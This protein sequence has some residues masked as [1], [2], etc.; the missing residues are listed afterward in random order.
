VNR[1]GSWFANL[2]EK[3]MRHT[4][5][6]ITYR[7]AHQAQYAARASELRKT[8]QTA[9]F[10]EHA[11]GA[12]RLMIDA[13]TTWVLT[14]F[15]RAEINPSDWVI[16][17]DSRC[18]EYLEDLWEWQPR[19]LLDSEAPLVELTRQLVRIASGESF[20]TTSRQT[21]RLTRTERRVLQSIAFGMEHKEI[22]A[23]MGVAVS[24]I[25]THQ[26]NL[27]RK[28]E[29]KRHRDALF[30]YLDLPHLIR[31]RRISTLRRR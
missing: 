27:Y 16:L 8:L 22:A 24:T 18:P 2:T 5:P 13:P 4:P 30:Y 11:R 17:T 12:L 25:K 23:V 19:A 26:R 21:S 6:S 15:A 1:L 29:L 7:I 31:A 20:N 10:R 14:Q 28:L 9:G 3:R